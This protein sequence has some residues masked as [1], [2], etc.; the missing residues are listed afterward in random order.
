MLLK[1]EGHVVNHKLVY[2]LYVEEGLGIR[3]RSPQRRKSV[4]IRPERPQARQSNESWSMDVMSD[5][6]CNGTRFRLLTL[7]AFWLGAI[8]V[9]RAVVK[10]AGIIASRGSSRRGRRSTLLQFVPASGRL[11][12]RPRSFD[13]SWLGPDGSDARSACRRRASKVESRH[14]H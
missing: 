8:I 4:Q 7:S 10:P 14:P 2:R 13:R 5:L 12:R 3:R 11:R 6:L 1:R 9:Y